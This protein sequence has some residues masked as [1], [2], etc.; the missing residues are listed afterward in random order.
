MFYDVRV[1]CRRIGLGQDW[2]VKRYVLGLPAHRRRER[3]ALNRSVASGLR[4]SLVG[5]RAEVREKAGRCEGRHD[6]EVPPSS[7]FHLCS[8]L[9]SH[10]Y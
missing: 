10:E 4:Q 5:S 3:L 1:G 9:R 8:L 6:S 7:A 2:V